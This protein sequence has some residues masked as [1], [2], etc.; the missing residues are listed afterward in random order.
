MTDYYPK[1]DGTRCKAC[2]KSLGDSLRDKELCAECL[3]VVKELN[4]DL[5]FEDE[6]SIDEEIKLST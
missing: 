2:D 5:Y 4:H 3:N 6:V 1:T